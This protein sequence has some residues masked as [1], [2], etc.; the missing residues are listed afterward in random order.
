[1]LCG[2]LLPSLPRTVVTLVLARPCFA[3]WCRQHHIFIGTVK[4]TRLHLPRISLQTFLGNRLAARYAYR[5]CHA[6]AFCLARQF[7]TYW[8]WRSAFSSAVK[9]S[10]RGGN[11]MPAFFRALESLA[12][13]RQR[14]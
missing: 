4:R 7:L 8:R 6:A 11:G 10:A 13:W 12:Y 2:C 5:Q 9:L 1:M 3:V 14:L